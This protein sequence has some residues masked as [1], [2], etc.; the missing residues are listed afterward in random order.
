M[1][2]LIL[3]GASEHNL[4]G[5]DLRLPRDSLICFT[6]VSGSGK[7][8]IAYDTIYR[9]GQRRFLESLSAYARQFIG[10]I[11]KPKLEHIEGLSP[12]VAIDQKSVSRNPRSTVGTVTEVWDFVRLLMARLG[13]PHCPE[14]GREVRAFAPE[15]IADSILDEGRAGEKLLVLAPVVRGR[16]GSYRRELEDWRKRGYVRAR[17]DGQVLR[18]DEEIR[19]GRYHK[20]DIELVMDRLRVDPEK[21]AR[22]LDSIEQALSV[23]EG[24]VATLLGGARGQ[25]RY[26]LYSSLRA[27]P[28][29]HGAIPEMEPRLFSFNSPQ[30]ACPA[31]DGLGESRGFV[32]ELLVAD[33]TRSLRE[34]AL[35][36]LNKK[37]FVHYTR[38][39]LDHIHR[40]LERFG[41]SADEPLQTMNVKARKALFHGTGDRVYDFRYAYDREKLSIRGRDRKPY[42][43]ILNILQRIWDEYR[44]RSLTR[45]Q[46]VVD[47]PACRGARLR[48]ESLAVTFRGAHIARFAGMTIGEAQ[49]FFAESWREIEA[50]GGRDEAIGRELF[51]ELEDR[52]GF[53]GKV[54]L[55]YLRLDRSAA[56]LSGGESQRIRLAAQVGSGLRGVLYILDEPSIGLHARDNQRL[57]ATLHEL[58]D[59]GNTVCVVEHDEETM[60]ASDYLVDVGPGAG[61]LGGEIVA[62]GPPARVEQHEASLT[63]SYLRGESAIE[64]P[65]R[66]R[67]GKRFLGLY[68]AAQHNLKKIDVRIPLGC[69]VGVTGVS[70]SGKSS[71]VHHVLKKALSRELNGADET[72]GRHR[73]LTGLEHL[74]KVIEIDQ[75]PIGRTPRSNPA[76]YTKVWTEIRDLY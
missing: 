52:L 8:S 48:P 24:L 34:G 70:G 66:R 11:E 30:G 62:E 5:V 28:E 42:R 55:G 7:S 33:E 51:R 68:G 29:G 43:G 64:V 39:H 20:H 74:D 46:S 63:A 37:G 38:C 1:D 31:C 22:L 6:G 16:K 44:P 60:R 4:K 18:L 35:H 45:F 50:R 65:E 27:C 2:E 12:T 40:V 73:R 54:G 69:L 59:R 57:I 71:L 56:T 17:I 47:C 23:G 26:R 61:V 53:L 10:R 3:K 75:S 67:P 49:A 21:R 25:E 41:G 15:Q 9:E 13:V 58:R 72:P 19:L 14:C 32:E 76:T 36:C